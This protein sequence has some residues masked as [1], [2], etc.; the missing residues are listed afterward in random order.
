MLCEIPS[1][2]KTKSFF[3]GNKQYSSRIMISV[4][5]SVIYDFI[6]IT[7]DGEL[8]IELIITVLEAV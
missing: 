4:S 7:N 5:A 1:W 8:C 3:T 6:R 2:K